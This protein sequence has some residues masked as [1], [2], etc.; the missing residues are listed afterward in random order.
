MLFMSIYTYG[1][2]QRD[3]AFERRGQGLS[4]PEVIK[5]I[6]QGSYVAGGRVF[7]LYEADDTLAIAQFAH[8]WNDI[9]ESAIFPVIDT[10]EVLKAMAPKERQIYNSSKS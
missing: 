6:G 9:G 3:E 7:T 10:E 2:A 1:P 8:G 4:L 5:L